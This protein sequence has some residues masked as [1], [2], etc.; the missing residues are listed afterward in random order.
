MQIKYK[1]D[2][3]WDKVFR[4]LKYPG[5]TCIVI[6]IPLLKQSVRRA[7]R[8]RYININSRVKEVFNKEESLEN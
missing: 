2:N 1:N 3:S 6:I 5:F 4:D 8:I 7:K